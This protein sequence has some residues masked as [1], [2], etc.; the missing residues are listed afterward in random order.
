AER[1][2]WRVANFTGSI[3]ACAA[4]AAAAFAAGAYFAAS[5]QAG[6]AR[7][8]LIISDR[9]WIRVEKVSI[10]RFQVV[11]KEGGYV[12]G[13]AHIDVKNFGHSPAINLFINSELKPLGSDQNSLDVR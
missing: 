5:E 7:D 9:P 11:G 13:L 8:A 10:D 2:H 4:V 1:A 3:A 12:I 6:I